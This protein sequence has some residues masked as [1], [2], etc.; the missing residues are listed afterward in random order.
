MAPKPNR[1]AGYR[2]SQV[3]YVRATCLYLATKLGDLLDEIVIVGGLVPS[4]LI[5]QQTVS[6]ADERHVGTLD[7]DI[8]L[9]LAILDDQRYQA[10]TERLRQAGF[11]EDT[12]DEGK[13][14][15]QRWRI[16]GP[17]KVTVDFLIPPSLPEDRPGK[18]RN[19]E[20]DFAAIIAPGLHL[21]FRDRERVLLDG[22]TILGEVATREIWVA[23]P[24]A[25]VVLK[26]LAFKSRGE[27]KDAYDLFYVLRHFG[28]GTED[29]VARSA[30][31]LDDPY[32]KEAIA[33]LESDFS[34]VDSLGPRRVAEFL[35]GSP[36]D[37]LEADVRNLVLDFVTGCKGER[38][39]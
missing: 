37:E 18:L 1:A 28:Q 36:D 14:T 16:D 22:R 3:E 5:D 30:A 25:Y 4:L 2:T 35:N 29:V 24:A 26:A 6:P 33:V 23:G 9:A 13:P 27:N 20:K 21:A 11:S 34:Q 8:G 10:L 32:A 19:I 15:R 12:T 7:L 17:P 39:G 31:L 38:S